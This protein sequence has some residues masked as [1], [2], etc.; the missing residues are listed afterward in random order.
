MSFGIALSG[1]AAAQ[2]DLNVTANNISNSATTGFKQSRTEFS[3][4]YSASLQGVSATQ[5]GNG[6]KVASISQQFSQGNLTSTDSSLDLAISGSGFFAVSDNG[7]LEYTRSGA[8]SKDNSGYVVNSSGQRLQVYAA[9]DDGTFNTS[10]LTDLRMQTSESAPA[11][12]TE[13]EAIFNLPADA[14]EPATATLDP[15]DSTSYN[16]ATS[17]TVYD[18]LGAAHTGTLYFAKTAN[19]NEWNASLYVDGAAVGTAQTLSYSS[20][21]ELTSPASG[22]VS[23]GAYTP[24]TGADDIDVTFNFSES[25]QYGD[26]FSVSSL[27][28]NGYTTGQLTDVTVD[29][30]GVV[31]ANF[32]NGQS[33]SLGQVAVVNFANPQGLQQVDGT[34]WVETFASG[35]PVNGQAGNAEFGQIQSGSLEASNVDLTEQLVNMIVAQR[36][37]QANAQMIS[38]EK[39][40]TETVINMA[41]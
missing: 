5:E 15:A 12:T 26:T 18:S 8:F 14:E 30:S 28:Q 3:E 35:Q 4:L 21:G 23:F 39:S 38:T 29:G 20:S 24:A 33:R 31:Q 16:K 36:N 11:A 34:N 22:Q 6:V 1:L 27:S 13:A 17:L 32:T 2:T 9:N 19:A 37:Y 41:R 7:S 10:T 25:T 40:I